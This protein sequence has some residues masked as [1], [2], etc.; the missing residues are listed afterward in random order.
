MASDV[1]CV[2]NDV[3][4]TCTTLLNARFM[5]HERIKRMD[6]QEWMMPILHLHYLRNLRTEVYAKSG[7]NGDIR[8]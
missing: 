8:L 6:G 4:R 7:K 2:L 3:A 5:Y 1:A